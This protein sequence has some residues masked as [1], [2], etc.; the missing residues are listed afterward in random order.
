MKTYSLHTKL[1]LLTATLINMISGSGVSL[2]GP[3]CSKS[4]RLGMTRIARSPAS[5][6]A[7]ACWLLGLVGRCFQV[8]GTLSSC[9][10]SPSC[11]SHNLFIH[12]ASRSPA[13]V[14]RHYQTSHCTMLYKARL[15]LILNIVFQYHALYDQMASFADKAITFLIATVVD[16]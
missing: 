8:A 2:C 16:L 3:Y 13:A 4:A 12:V 10:K 9:L 15:E 5:Q 6:R 7:C 11:Q 14:D 1:S